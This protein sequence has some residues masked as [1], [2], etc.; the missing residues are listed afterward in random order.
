MSKRNY[1]AAFP[2]FTPA[3]RQLFRRIPE[4]RRLSMNIANRLVDATTIEDLGDEGPDL[5]IPNEN[6]YDMLPP[7]LQNLQ[8]SRPTFQTPRAP[9]PLESLSSRDAADA[10]WLLLQGFSFSQFMPVLHWWLGTSRTQKAIFRSWYTNVLEDEGR[11]IMAD[12]LSQRKIVQV[13]TQRPN[14]KKQFLGY[15]DKR[16]Q[17]LGSAKRSIYID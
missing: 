6:D 11:V 7:N 12:T 10:R 1:T 15:L 13:L 8:V 2:A 16:E 4:T 9:H 3:S 17:L 5:T 14:L